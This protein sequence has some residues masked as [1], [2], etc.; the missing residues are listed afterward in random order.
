M[1]LR[2]LL[3]ASLGLVTL[4]AREELVLERR[5]A[6][7]FEL[8]TTSFELR[9]TE[10]ER[11][12]EQRPPAVRRSESQLVEATDR[13]DDAADPLARF[14]RTYETVSSAFSFGGGAREPDEEVVTA[15]LEGRTVRFEREGEDEWSRASSGEGVNERQLARLR[16]D[17]SLAVF[18]PPAEHA[19]DEPWELGYAPFERLIGPLGPVGAR[20]R[21]RTPGTGGGLDLAPSGLV[22]PLW[23]LLARAEG[24]ATFT[25]VEPEADAALPRL[26]TFEFR[27]EAE[28]DGAKHLVRGREVEAE[29]EVELA[30]EG[31]GTLAWDPESGVIELALAGE[32]D[33]TEE[34]RVSFSANGS[35]AEL[36]GSLAMNGPLELE[37]SERRAE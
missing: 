19:A 10:G 30:F 36:E 6:L 32:L 28:H 4:P 8:A 3:A 5:F 15:G 34:L 2:A 17:L 27:F 35:T 1:S 16:A 31:T 22:E 25:P 23:L 21:R 33:L 29:D 18:L 20:Q 13:A 37:A 26:A 7:E 24:T 12:E 9:A 11:S 14:A